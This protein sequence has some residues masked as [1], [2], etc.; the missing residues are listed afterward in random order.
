MSLAPF[1]L[2]LWPEDVPSDLDDA[3][4]S[5]V[6][7]RLVVAGQAPLRD[8]FLQIL[9]QRLSATSYSQLKLFQ[10]T[11]ELSLAGRWR[12]YYEGNVIAHDL[13]NE[14]DDAFVLR[15]MWAIQLPLHVGMDVGVATAGPELI[16]RVS[17]WLAGLPLN[18]P[19][20]RIPLWR[21]WLEHLLATYPHYATRDEKRA[22]RERPRRGKQFM[23]LK[24][25][26][27]WPYSEASSWDGHSNLEAGRE[28]RNDLFVSIYIQI[29]QTLADLQ[30]P[31]EAITETHETRQRG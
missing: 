11:S 4:T 28:T 21:I 20:P 23:K 24:M 15:L 3:K 16:I 17:R 9:L 7:M 29:K 27:V 1:T 13:T 2:N 26:G 8:E 19:L 5:L 12:M 31:V 10:G 30:V 18:V 25:E 14:G 22:I 6:R